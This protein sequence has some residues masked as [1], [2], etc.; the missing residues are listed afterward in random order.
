[1]EV[2][3][4]KENTKGDNPGDQKAKEEITN[5]NITNRLQEIE[6]RISRVEDTLE[7]IDTTV[8]ENTKSKKLLTQ[9]FK[10]YGHSERTEPKNNRYRR[11]S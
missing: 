4:L 11:D 6:E 2:E 1:M 8:K 7:D 10:K 9:K 3:I 5:A